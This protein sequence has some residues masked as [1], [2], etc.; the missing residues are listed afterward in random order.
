M[1]GDVRGAAG[2]ELPEGVLAVR[3]GPGANCSSIGSVVDMLFAAAVAAGVLYV[4]VAASL[5]DRALEQ[6]GDDAR[7]PRED[8][9]EHERE[10]DADDPRRSP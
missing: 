7:A 8:E 5:G 9:D 6:V 10:A 3:A 1:P 2:V 4:G